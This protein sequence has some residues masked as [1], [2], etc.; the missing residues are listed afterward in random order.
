MTA[1]FHFQA[2]TVPLLISMPHVGTSIAPEVAAQ[3]LPVAAEKAD[4]DWHLPLL[5]NMAQDLGA[6]MLVAEY[7]RYVIDLNRAPDNANLYPGQDTT[8]LCPVDTFHKQALYAPDQLPDQAEVQRRIQHYWQPYHQQLQRELE[9]LLALHGRVVLWD[10]HSIA[11]V[12]PRFFQGRLPDLNFGTADQKA[13]APALQQALADS[14]HSTPAAAPYSH[15]FNGRFKGGYITRHYGQPERDIH[16]VQLEMSQCVY[17]N[18]A[19]PYAYRPDLAQQ[20]QPVLQALLSRCIAFAQ[21][22]Q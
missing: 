6:S 7:S 21:G 10:A 16:A 17:M 15:V 18:E 3:M 4:T 11:S 1:A 14:L 5:Y 19:A 12:V 2:G 22:E 8:G 9:R 20:V 13:C